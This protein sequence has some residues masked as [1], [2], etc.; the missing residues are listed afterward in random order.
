MS[1]FV[2]TKSN[3]LQKGTSGSDEFIV[4]SGSNLDI[5][6]ASG[7][8]FLS[9][10]VSG[11]TSINSYDKL[12]SITTLVSDG[13]SSGKFTSFETISIIG[14]DANDSIK[15]NGEEIPPNISLN[16]GSGIDTLVLPYTHYSAE[17]FNIYKQET[18][19]DSYVVNTLKGSFTATNFEIIQLNDGYYSN[20]N[21]RRNLGIDVDVI[22]K[23]SKIIGTKYNDDHLGFNSDR[24]QYLWADSNGINLGF[25]GSST[26]TIVEG[27][28]YIGFF[29]STLYVPS[30]KIV[31]TPYENGTLYGIGSLQFVTYNNIKIVQVDGLDFSTFKK[32]SAT[33]ADTTSPTIS[34]SSDSSNL[35]YSQ[36]ANI[37]FTLS[38]V[39]SN[40]TVSDVTVAGGSVS[41]FSGSGTNYTATFV[42]AA[43][44]VLATIRV[45]SGAFT[46][47]AG[48]ANNDGLE[49]N[50]SLSFT[51]L[52][53][54]KYE[55][56][57]LSVIVDK[58]VLGVGAVLL[59]GLTEKLTITNGIA[60]AH[61]VEYAGS[62]FDY[63]QIDALITTVV[64]DGEFS[65]EFR[66]ELTDAL[67]S[68]ANLSYGDA[69]V[70]VGTAN[71]D[72]QLLYVAGI[73]GNF[74][75]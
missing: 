69:V 6:G 64:R 75:A 4:N 44:A 22:T 46:D 65:A 27:I 3:P 67:P 26:S 74:V 41:N 63:N 71:I 66:K 30:G 21:M 12:N 8:D 61:T 23:L 33:P 49:A 47:A 72:S 57:S 10:Y 14:S 37:K 55:I 19:S 24:A 28:E 53:E 59:K 9:V 70:L 31:S 32:M 11:N 60:S 48:N 51:I 52:Q 17:T 45:A 29:S 16:G 42:P 50:N 34:L 7:I 2:V 40:F 68:T 20:S 36:T 38:E 39:S 62:T 58:G 18:G 54:V 56:H 43:G 35:S 73:D 25:E 15:L 1:S 13:I 5:D